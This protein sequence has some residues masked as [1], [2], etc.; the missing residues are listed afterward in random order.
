MLF[1]KRGKSSTQIKT[2]EQISSLFL[3]YK[4]VKMAKHMPL[5]FIKPSDIVIKSSKTAQKQFLW[6]VRVN[7]YQT[8]LTRLYGLKK[9]LKWNR[10]WMLSKEQTLSKVLSF[11]SV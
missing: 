6:E 5:D 2:R 3:L 4:G 8:E 11:G 10:T 1:A 9:P 7:I